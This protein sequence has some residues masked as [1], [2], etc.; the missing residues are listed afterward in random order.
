MTVPMVVCQQAARSLIMF[1]RPRTFQNTRTYTHSAVVAMSFMVLK[2]WQA[3]A[4]ACLACCMLSLLK[5]SLF[6]AELHGRLACCLLDLLPSAVC[7]LWSTLMVPAP[8]RFVRR[9]WVEGFLLRFFYCKVSRKLPPV[10]KRPN[11]KCV[12][13]FACTPQTSTGGHD[14]QTRQGAQ[15]HIASAWS[16]E[17]LA[18]RV[19]QVLRVLAEPGILTCCLLARNYAP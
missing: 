6:V 9:R 5:Q 2:G 13:R 11:W 15:R 4:L 12:T 14:D 16:F 3:H 10:G 8:A 17:W 18:A 7:R 19:E 1:C